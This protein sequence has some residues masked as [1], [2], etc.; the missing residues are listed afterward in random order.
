MYA[1]LSWPP[2]AITAGCRLNRTVFHI[3]GRWRMIPGSTLNTSCMWWVSGP[4]RVQG[5][6]IDGVAR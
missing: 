6:G 3:P 1:L 2:E 4:H 5:T